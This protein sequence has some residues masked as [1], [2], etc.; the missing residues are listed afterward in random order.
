MIKPYVIPLSFQIKNREKQFASH[1]LQQIKLQKQLNNNGRNG[2]TVRLKRLVFA[3]L[4]AV[5][6]KNSKSEPVHAQGTGFLT[7][8]AVRLWNQGLSAAIITN[9]QLGLIKD[10]AGL[11]GINNKPELQFYFIINKF[12]TSYFNYDINY[13]YYYHY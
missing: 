5:E 9:V 3:Q 11:V 1:N 8:T 4:P 2:R 6:E 7:V 13:H 10:S 12:F